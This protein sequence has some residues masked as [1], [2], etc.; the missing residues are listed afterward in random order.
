LAYIRYGARK[1]D[2]ELQMALEA[3]IQSRL[4]GA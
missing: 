3:L 2:A 4:Q 1:L